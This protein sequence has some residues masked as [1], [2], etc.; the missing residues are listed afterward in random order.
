MMIIR[1][2]LFKLLTYHGGIRVTRCIKVLL[3]AL[4]AML[5]VELNLV[6]D[7]MDRP[8]C[9]FF[10]SDLE[11]EVQQ[12][13]NRMWQV[14]LEKKKNVVPLKNVIDFKKKLLHD[15]S[16]VYWCPV[17]KPSTYSWLLFDTTTKM[18]KVV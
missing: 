17:F 8:G 10:T 6:K 3:L 9:S 7:R 4:M 1:R 18:N 12:R 16:Y 15:G 13:R 14:C 11:C 2:K 5:V